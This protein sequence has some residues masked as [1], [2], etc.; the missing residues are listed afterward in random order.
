MN[1]T[2]MESEEVFALTPQR[3]DDL[4]SDLAQLPISV[5]V[6]ASAA[7]PVAL[8]PMSLRNYSYESCWGPIPGGDWISK[9][10]TLTGPR[11]IDLENYK[12]ARYANAL[13]NGPNAY[14]NEHY[15]HLLDGGLADNQG[16]QSL[17]D[18]LI[19]PHGP[20]PLLA[21]INSGRARRIA[22]ISVNARSDTDNH[23]GSNPAV[24]G[25]LTV[26]NNVIGTPIDATTARAN[27]ALQNLEATL[28]SAGESASAAP[29]NPKFGGLR[30]Y[31]IAVDFDQFLPEQTQMQTDVK[32]IGTS[33]T[34]SPTQLQESIDA[35]RILLR[36]HPCFERLL[37][38][39]HAIAPA[40]AEGKRAQQFC[41]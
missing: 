35:G 41:P 8:S 2:D 27:A 4:C 19:S 3:F 22:V 32:N 28:K 6:A 20:V 18:A 12:R 37:L 34:L 17:S 29:G 23:I 33:W 31:G 38:D 24:P 1:A 10:L 15:I 36:Q 14:R 5:G 21:D 40:S 9:E 30:V 16:G 26:V 11:Y 7:F 25:L 39:L 13:R